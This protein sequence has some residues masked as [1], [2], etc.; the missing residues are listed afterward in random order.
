MSKSVVEHSPR[1]ATVND[2]FCWKLKIQRLARIRY[3]LCGLF[4][5]GSGLKVI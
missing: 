3:D 5:S 2:G 1:E 4:L